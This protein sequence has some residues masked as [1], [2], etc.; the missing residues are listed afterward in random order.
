MKTMIFKSL[1]VFLF[2]LLFGASCE[3]DKD[4]N[5]LIVKSVS[6]SK[7]TIWL[8]VQ[9]Q[10][11]SIYSGLEGTYD[12]QDIGI[13]CNLPDSFK[14]EGFEILFSGNYYPCNAFSPSIP[15]QTYYFLDITK[16]KQLSEE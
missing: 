5:R 15:G 8:D 3:K 9:S 11:Y 13:A 4:V 1:V 12:S 16:I 10:K 7:G 6:D 2:I 14:I